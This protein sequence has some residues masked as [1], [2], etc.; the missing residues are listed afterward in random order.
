M[1]INELFEEKKGEDKAKP[2]AKP[3][4][5]SQLEKDLKS[6]MS[7]KA[8]GDM[9]KTIARDNKITPHELHVLFVDQ[10][11]DTPDDWIRKVK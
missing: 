10:H 4:A 11:G 6:P 3:K 5:V 7:Y 1:K 2:K 8:I 9:M